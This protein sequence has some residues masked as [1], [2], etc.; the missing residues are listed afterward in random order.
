MKN[1]IFPADASTAEKRYTEMQDAWRNETVS[2]RLER[3]SL[4][5]YDLCN[6]TVLE[7]HSKV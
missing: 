3:I 4:E 1:E 6:G 5:T 7:D 2:G